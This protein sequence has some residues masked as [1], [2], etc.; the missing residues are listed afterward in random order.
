MS[1]SARLPARAPPS[2]QAYLF[3]PAAAVLGWRQKEPAPG[4]AGC[5]LLTLR[6]PAPL[7]K[8]SKRKDPDRIAPPGLTPKQT[9]K[10]KNQKAKTPLLPP[11]RKL[12]NI[13]SKCRSGGLPSGAPPLPSPR[14]LRWVKCRGGGLK[15]PHGFAQASSKNI[16]ASLKDPPSALMYN[17]LNFVRLERGRATSR[18]SPS[19]SNCLPGGASGT[20]GFELRP[21]ERPRDPDREIPLRIR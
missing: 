14:V 9:S 3:D 11:T 15:S 20:P 12:Q 17:P 5:R 13:P 10:A 2:R 4:R 18:R 21:N 1:W 8:T 7:K 6:Y 19:T 16:K